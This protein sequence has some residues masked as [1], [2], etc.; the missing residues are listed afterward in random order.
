LLEDH[1][2]ILVWLGVDSEEHSFL[3]M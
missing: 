1:I 2:Y 3:G